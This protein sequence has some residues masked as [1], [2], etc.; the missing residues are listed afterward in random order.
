MDYGCRRSR[1]VKSAVSFGSSLV[2]GLFA[3][4]SGRQRRQAPGQA[5][6]EG[7]TIFFTKHSMATED[8]W[9]LPSSRE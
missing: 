2:F 6:R 8:L 3:F 4:S 7:K 1:A 5:H 9:H